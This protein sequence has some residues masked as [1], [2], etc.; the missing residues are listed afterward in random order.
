LVSIHLAGKAR[1]WHSKRNTK[2]ACYEIPFTYK[3]LLSL[4]FNKENH[5]KFNK[6]IKVDDKKNLLCCIKLFKYIL[7]LEISLLKILFVQGFRVCRERDA[8]VVHL[9]VSVCMYGLQR[10]L[11]TSFCL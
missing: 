9:T 4:I 11:T 5:R 6:F 10:E 1:C 8:F 3:Q 7:M 2:H